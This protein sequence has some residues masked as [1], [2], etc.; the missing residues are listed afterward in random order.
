MKKLICECCGGTINRAT[1]TCEYCGTKYKE[2]H[3]EV[4]RI[5]TFMNPV[6]TLQAQR[7]IPDFELQYIGPKEMSEACL[8]SMAAELAECMIPYMR[9]QQE[10]DFTRCTHRVRAQVR[11]VQPKEGQWEKLNFME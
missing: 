7:E 8:K 11:V 2:E 10:Y 9:V 1:M 3:D 4:I 5:E 6:R